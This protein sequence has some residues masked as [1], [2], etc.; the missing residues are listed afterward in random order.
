MTDAVTG[1]FGYSG[2]FI[3]RRLLAAGR[4]VRTLT[5]SPNR[6]N[7][8]GGRIAVHPLAFG[9]PARL[10]ESLRGVE[11]LYNTYW[12]RFNHR[13]FNHAEAVGNSGVL[14]QAARQ[15]GVKRIVHVSI[16]NPSAGSPFE[17]FSG[18]AEVERLLAA[19]GVAHS[20]LRPAVLFG[21]GDILVNN[22]AWMLR[23]MPFFGV[24]GDGNYGIR[25]I[26]VD[27]LA[28]LA[29][30]HGEQTANAIVDAVGPERFTYR[31]LVKAIA[32][33]LGL[34]RAVIGLPP[35]L[36]WLGGRLAGLVMRD[37]MITWEEVG[38][39]MAGLLDS[40]A[41]AAGPT[42]L[43][44]WV[45]EHAATL[46]RIYAHELGRRADRIHAYESIGGTGFATERRFT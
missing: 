33:G 16:L 18:K 38:G 22:I 9:D 45:R 1:A 10:A 5:N 28:A 11:V 15:A 6:N 20:I 41:P 25:P 30:G 14:F 40:S 3:A 35:R 32:S 26:H 7:E 44:G 46:G 34:R 4:G 39:L 8:F 23:R 43:T 19:S 21:H 17:Y 24:F 29:V 31:E 42:S 12:V 13:T 2:R 27:D 37:E 36:A